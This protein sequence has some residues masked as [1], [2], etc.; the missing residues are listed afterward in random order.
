M[1]R[2]AGHRL[3]EAWRWRWHKLTHHG[4]LVHGQGAGF[5]ARWLATRW[6]LYTA[7]RLGTKP[8][9]VLSPSDAAQRRRSDT[10]FVFGSGYSLNDVSP[11]EWEHFA[12]HDIFGFSGFIYQSWV[13]TD[14]HLVRGWDETAEGPARRART[15][16]AY[17]RRIATNPHFSDTVL[18]LQAEPEAEF[19]NTLLARRLLA[20][21][22]AVLRYRTA[23]TLGDD[24]SETWNAG[25]THGPGTLADV[26]NAAFLLGWREIVLAGVDMY[27]SRYFWGPPDAT[28][29]FDE[30]GEFLRVTPS[31]D[32]AIR[33]DGTVHTARNGMIETLGRW[34]DVLSARGVRLFV[35][36]PR[37]LLTRVLPVYEGTPRP[38]STGVTGR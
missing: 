25:L 24:P 8:Y 12:A 32:H 27:D 38:A 26:V 33:W 17:A 23:R 30:H 34:A 20:P 10:V 11:A 2:A 5:Y 28:L 31:N 22:T 29:D 18:I 21:G 35:Y 15:T 6:A 4:R 37:S 13:R 16:A 19:G 36:N 1:L 14:F 3:P 9:R 7:A